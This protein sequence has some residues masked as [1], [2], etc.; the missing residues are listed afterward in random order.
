MARF[1]F[2]NRQA[3]AL[4]VL[5]QL[6]I[7]L[8]LQASPIFRA[9]KW[10]HPLPAEWAMT[11]RRRPASGIFLSRHLLAV[12]QPERGEMPLPQWEKLPVSALGEL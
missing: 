6:V 7:R 12:G 4:T 3:M 1:N 5:A 11:R 9:L 8:P 2:T 10:G